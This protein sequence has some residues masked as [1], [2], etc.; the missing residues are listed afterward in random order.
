MKIKQ[1]IRLK[2]DIKIFED[3]IMPAGSIG[4]ICHIYSNGKAYEVE[5]SDGTI[6]TLYTELI[7]AI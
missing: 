3:D 5:F 4:S 6:L 1:S 2:Q 7:E